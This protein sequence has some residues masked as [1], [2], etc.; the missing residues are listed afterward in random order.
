MDVSGFDVPSDADPPGHFPPLQYDDKEGIDMS[1]MVKGGPATT[2]TGTKVRVEG[3]WKA[4][5]GGDKSLEGKLKA[6]KGVDL[7]VITVGLQ[8]KDPKGICWFDDTNPFNNGSLIAGKDA[9]GRRKLMGKKD[10][11]SREHHEVDLSIVPSYVDTLIFTVSAYKPDVTFNDV[12]SVTC[13]ITVDGMPWEPTRVTI[14]AN[15]NTCVMLRAKRNGDTW[16]LSLVDQL[17]TANT[18]SEIMEQAA[19]YA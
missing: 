13:N 15:Q 12:S 9:S 1:M 2:I 17:V 18:Q 7:D 4:T 5:S 3:V 6:L 16:E 14:N 10:P 8:G 11:L 19:R